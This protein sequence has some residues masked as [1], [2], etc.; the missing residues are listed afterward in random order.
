MEL[1]RPASWRYMKDTSLPFWL[2]STGCRFVFSPPIY[3]TDSAG[4]LCALCYSTQIL[5]TGFPGLTQLIMKHK[6]IIE[7]L[8]HTGSQLFSLFFLVIL[9]WLLSVCHCTETTLHKLRP[10]MMMSLGNPS[11]LAT[12]KH[13]SLL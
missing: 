5:K 10:I 6:T 3:G 4:N 2:K 8:S 7:G 12:S 13:P 9:C 1:S 11:I